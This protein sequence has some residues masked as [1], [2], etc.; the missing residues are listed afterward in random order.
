MKMIKGKNTLPKFG[1]FILLFAFGFVL[2]FSS[3]KNE[4]D[5]IADYKDT[6]IVYAL[7]NPTDS[8]QY[9]R[10]HKAFVGEGNALEMAQYTDS[11]YYSSNLKVQLEEYKDGFLKRTITCKEDTSIKK[12][13]G[14]FATNPN[15]L[16]AAHDSIKQGNDYKLIIT[17]GE[18]A[19]PVTSTTIVLSNVFLIRPTGFTINF[20]DTPFVIIW[21][22]SPYGVVYEP[23][24]RFY[25]SETEKLNSQNTV[26]KYVDMRLGQKSIKE[27]DVREKMEVGLEATSFFRFVG[28]TIKKDT[29][30]Y[31]NALSLEMI[32]YGGTQELYDYY[33]INNLTTNLAQNIPFYTNITNG[34]GIFTSRR[35]DTYLKQLSNES[36]DELKNGEFTKHLGFK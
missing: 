13:A 6:T 19:A 21:Y 29:T 12:D 33:R 36:L 24:F 18:T 25:Y 8:V 22:T 16:Y 1:V 11:F 34:I 20:L 35:K 5:L 10:I 27:T 23:V 4:I 30:V 14:I 7:L 32:I 17:R 31:R 28:T 15:L 9:I 2:F 3:C 26:A